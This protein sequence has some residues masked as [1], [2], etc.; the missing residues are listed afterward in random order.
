V[1]RGRD[2]LGALHVGAEADDSSP[3]WTP[4]MYGNRGLDSGRKAAWREACADVEGVQQ[5]PPVWSPVWPLYRTY[6]DL[7]KKRK[8]TIRAYEAACQIARDELRPR[9][10]KAGRAFFTEQLLPLIE[11]LAKRLDDYEAL[12]EEVFRRTHTQLPR[13]GR[14]GFTAQASGMARQ[15]GTRQRVWPALTAGARPGTGSRMFVARASTE[16]LRID[17][18]RPDA[19]FG[20][21]E[22]FTGRPGRP[23]TGDGLKSCSCILTYR[24]SPDFLRGE[25]SGNQQDDHAGNC[26]ARA[27]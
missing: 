23:P 15:L 12:R 6:L 16:S 18:M 9:A 20:C 25:R 7:T 24:R 3:S 1:G 19:H 10:Y 13:L 4:S 21:G 26:L 14:S 27:E 2:Q 5:Q 11:E 8:G 22:A 17:A